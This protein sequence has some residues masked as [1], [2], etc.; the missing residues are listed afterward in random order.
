MVAI[1]NKKTDLSLKGGASASL[2]AEQFTS[3]RPNRDP[4]T[5]IDISLQTPVGKQSKP[6][7]LREGYISKLESLHKEVGPELTAQRL[8][9]SHGWGYQ[10][11]VVEPDTKYSDE[12][13]KSFK[14]SGGDAQYVA[15]RPKGP[16]PMRANSLYANNESVASVTRFTI[17]RDGSTIAGKNVHL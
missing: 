14:H 5:A 8:T 10:A 7:N 3:I 17:G 12:P 9:G 16:L 4:A 15:S 2:E 6:W 11:K 13:V 1:S